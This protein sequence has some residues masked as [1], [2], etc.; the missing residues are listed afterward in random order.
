[1]KS[2]AKDIFGVAPTIVGFF[3]IHVSDIFFEI[4]ISVARYTT[5]QDASVGAIRFCLQRRMFV[6]EANYVSR[7]RHFAQDQF[8]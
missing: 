7:K 1:M 3:L 4:E 8:F 2:R 5:L 6:Q